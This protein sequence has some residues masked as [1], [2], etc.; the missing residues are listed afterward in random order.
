ML[1]DATFDDV[2]SQRGKPLLSTNGC[3]KYDSRK[4]VTGVKV[5]QFMS[6]GEVRGKQEA[7][8][9][10][11]GGEASSPDSEDNDL[12]EAKDV[13]SVGISILAA[14]AYKEFGVTDGRCENTSEYAQ[15][16]GFSVPSRFRRQCGWARR[17]KRREM[18]GAKYIEPY[19]QIMIELFRQ[20]SKDK[21]KKMGP[22]AM[23]DY[24][25]K[26]HPDIFTLPGFTEIQSFIS[27]LF[28]KEKQGKEAGSSQKELK[29][30]K[31]YRSAIYAIV[32]K[33]GGKIMPEY[34][35]I[36]FRS[37]FSPSNEPDFPDSKDIRAAASYRKQHCV[38]MKKRMLIG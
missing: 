38:A 21:D 19:K 36:K 2:A 12:M 3:D 14:G 17:Q 20:G 15:A 4:T 37:E 27:Q 13:I 16:Q 11:L 31:K 9:M 30:A 29:V 34:V 7:E 22:G 33:Y 25:I 32:D 26:Q 1:A 8:K 35:E 6:L 5:E 18:Y 28:N 23:R 24:L 10:L